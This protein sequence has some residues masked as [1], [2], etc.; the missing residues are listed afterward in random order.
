MSMKKLHN[1]L[2]PTLFTHWFHTD[3]TQ[4]LNKQDSTGQVDV[5][6]TYQVM[7]RNEQGSSI[8][9]HDY[10]AQKTALQNP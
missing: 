2:D 1:P 6:F 7:P 3:I 5:C 8:C 10:T 4:T 9:E